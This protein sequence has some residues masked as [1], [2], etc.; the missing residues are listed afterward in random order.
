MLAMDDRL[1]A[2]PPALVHEGVLTGPLTPLAG[3][4]GCGGGQPSRAYVGDVERRNDSP[5]RSAA[6]R[7]ETERG[8]FSHGTQSPCFAVSI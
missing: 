8:S 7:T 5:H 4:G 3:R 2:S 6:P 1:T